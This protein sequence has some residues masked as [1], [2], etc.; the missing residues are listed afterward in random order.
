MPRIQNV[1]R[2]C[3]EEG[4]HIKPG[5][6]GA[7]LIQI[8]DPDCSFPHP[9]WPFTSTLQ[10]KF[11]DIEDDQECIDPDWRPN[12]FHA[13]EIVWQLRNALQKGMD[14]VVHCHAGICRSGAVAEAGVVMGFESTGGY[15]QPNTSLKRLLFRA[16]GTGSE[17]ESSAF[18]S[19]PEEDV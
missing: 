14:V 8:V 11:L 5:P 19:I 1:S 12:E 15:G 6:N 10:V 16:M 7:L 9:A 2:H 3:I 4:H 13:S 18:N 17:P